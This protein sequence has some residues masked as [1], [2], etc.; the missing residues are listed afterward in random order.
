MVCGSNT[1]RKMKLRRS[2]NDDAFGPCPLINFKTKVFNVKTFLFV[3]AKQ[4]FFLKRLHAEGSCLHSYLIKKFGPPLYKGWTP[5]GYSI[6]AN[7][8]VD[9][10]GY[11]FHGVFI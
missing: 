5:M 1:V 10:Y 9:I 6:T 7:C 4:V 3:V 8:N 2:R 11:K